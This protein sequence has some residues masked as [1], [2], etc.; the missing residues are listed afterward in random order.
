MINWFRMIIVRN[1][2]CLSLASTLVHHRCFGVRVAHLFSFLCCVLG[3]VLLIFL[4]F[5]VVFWG[6]VAHPFSFLCCV[7]GPVLLIFLVLCVVF[8]ILFV[9]VLFFVPNISCVSGMSILDYPFGFLERLFI[10]SYYVL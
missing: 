4:V 3:S 9:F 10:F 7:L 2:N 8:S 6:R 1:R 5:R